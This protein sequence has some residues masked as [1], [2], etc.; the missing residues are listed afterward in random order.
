MKPFRF[1]PE[2]EKDLAE[3][4]DWYQKES[5]ALADRF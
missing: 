3:A 2:A 5:W 1:H 4:L